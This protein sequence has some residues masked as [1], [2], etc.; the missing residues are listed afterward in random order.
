MRYIPVG[1]VILE[2]FSLVFYRILQTFVGVNVLLTPIDNSNESEL[3][4]IHTT[5]QN[6]ESIRAGVHQVQL[7][8]HSDCPSSLRVYRACQFQR[9]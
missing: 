5:S 9:F 8:Q 6:I 3:E 4:G 2:E 1:R 7:G